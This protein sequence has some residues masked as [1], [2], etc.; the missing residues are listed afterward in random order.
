MTFQRR[1]FLKA[2]AAGL[3]LGS[4]SGRAAFS[5]AAGSAK[6]RVV[7]V[8][9]GFGGATAARY[10]RLW[11]RGGIEVTLVERNPNFISCPISN[12]VLGGTKTMADIS[13]G[14]EALKKRGVRVIQGDVLA[15]DAERR[16]VRLSDGNSLPYDRLILSPGIDFMY[17]T[18]PGLIPEAAES[19]MIPHAWKAGAQTVAL[20]KQLEKMPDG[21]TF[22][23]CIPKAPFRCQ[24]GPY[25]RAC[26][27]AH[28]FKQHKPKSK[29]LILDANDEPAAKKDLFRKVWSDIY[30]E[31][32]EYRSRHT[33][34]GVDVVQRR[35]EFE[36]D[37]PVKADVLNIIPA[38]KAGHIAQ[39][40]VNKNGRWVGV[41]WLSLESEVAPNIHVIG[42][43]TFATSG[44]PKSGHITNQQAKVVAAALLNLFAGQPVNPEP[45]MVN[46]CYSFVDPANAVHVVTVHAWDAQEKTFKLVPGSGGLSAAPSKLEAKFALAW[47][48]NIWADTLL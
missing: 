2:S 8:G 41:D 29:V 26:L 45:M 13:F 19:G 25:E 12:L 31:I 10:L 16:Q 14:Y 44:M 4:L 48:K 15:I 47:A 35:V 38:Q 11:S 5:F 37:E 21:G 9:G 28:Y 6:P 22:A 27:I 39:P 18:L 20:K 36:F 40:L 42:D 24:P 1:D 46:T 17:D 7:V 43:A 33:I 32:I 34:V 3:L 30:P 23:L